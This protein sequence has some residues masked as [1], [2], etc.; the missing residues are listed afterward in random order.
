MEEAKVSL[1]SDT[2]V[3]VTRSFKAPRALLYRAYT[4]PPLF[5]RWCGATPGWS[6]PVC[7]IDARVGGRYRWR[8]RNDE[9]TSEF[10]FTGV[11][12]EVEQDERLVYT[13]SYDAGTL[14]IGMGDGE[15]VVNV[16]FSESGG[17]TTV[18]TLL[19]YVSE[20]TR[21]EALASGMTDGMEQNFKLLDGLLDAVGTGGARDDD[22]GHDID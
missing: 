4:E 8:W 15:S 12:R 1:P 18:T 17:I 7:E 20:E 10:G 14:G 11:F 13:E 3:L 16:T 19:Q 22:P 5:R 21:D 2:E 6:M 9:G